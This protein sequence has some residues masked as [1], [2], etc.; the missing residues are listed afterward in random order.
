[1]SSEESEAAEDPWLTVA[2]IAEELRLSP[3]TVRSWVSQGRLP[4]TRSG[5]RK[6]LIRRSDIERM[7][8]QNQIEPDP[9]GPASGALPET[10]ETPR[11]S[12]DWNDR[13]REH[14][15]PK[16]WLGLSETFWRRAVDRSRMAPPDAGFA[17][18]LELLAKAAARKAAALA[19]LDEEP[20]AWWQRQGAIPDG[21]ITYELRPGGN[22]PGP[23][24]LWASFDATVQ[25]LNDA[26]ASHAALAELEALE[27]LSLVL[28]EIVD[29]LVE[30]G[31]YERPDM[32]EYEER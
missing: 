6:W 9:D 2:E 17:A 31:L 3:A 22:R 30:D 25:A 8:S 1:V 11:R 14:V 24:D 4:A 7:T 5:R 13:A 26:M 32:G 23:E 27:R 16:G 19:D 28:H 20:G 15:S 29:A 12:P 10:I 21:A 18:R